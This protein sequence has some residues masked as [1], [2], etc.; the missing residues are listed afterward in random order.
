MF[1]LAGFRAFCG[2][3][4]GFL[5]FWLV[6]LCFGGILV[7]FWTLRVWGWYNTCFGVLV[8]CGRFAICL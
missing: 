1:G 3:E 8:L 5:W 4:G 2:F 7:F 6:L